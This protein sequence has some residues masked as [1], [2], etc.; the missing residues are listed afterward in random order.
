[1]PVYIVKIDVIITVTNV[2]GHRSTFV[3]AYL[4]GLIDNCAQFIWS[5]VLG[6]YCLL[7]DYIEGVNGKRDWKA[8]RIATGEVRRTWAGNTVWFSK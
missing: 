5:P 2:F 8:D 6:R 7:Q 3:I 1:M 4:K